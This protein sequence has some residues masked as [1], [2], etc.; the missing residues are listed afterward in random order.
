[1]LFQ[2]FD[3]PGQFVNLFF[4]ALVAQL[5]EL[6]QKHDEIKERIV[7]EIPAQLRALGISFAH[8]VG[9]EFWRELLNVLHKPGRNLASPAVFHNVLFL[10]DVLAGLVDRLGLPVLLFGAPVVQ[11]HRSRN[12]KGLPGRD[13]NVF[14]GA[15]DRERIRARVIQD[16]RLGR[17]FLL[18]RHLRADSQHNQYAQAL[19]QN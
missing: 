11:R 12:P 1:M 3:L 16:G 19:D 17:L 18:G 6:V 5:V 4:V 14:L 13:R 9:W 15:R 7:T 2:V 10:K 8:A